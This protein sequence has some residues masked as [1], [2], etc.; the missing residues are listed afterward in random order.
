MI[1][2]TTIVRRNAR[3]EYRDL[4]EEGGAV[5]LHLGTGAYHGVN[6]VGA[7]VWGILGEAMTFGALLGQLRPQLEDVPPTLTDEILGFLEELAERDLVVLG[8]AAS[9]EDS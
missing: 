7:L 9:S 4:G 3:V 8:D 5:L 6:D 2:D 1:S